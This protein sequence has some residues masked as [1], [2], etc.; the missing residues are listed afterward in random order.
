MSAP[1]VRLSP[2]DTIVCYDQKVMINLT[3]D[4]NQIKNTSWNIP[5]Q[6]IGA[7]LTPNK[8]TKILVTIIDTNNCVTTATGIVKVK[9]CNT[10]ENC[11]AI[12]AAFTPNNDGK[13]D[14][15]MPIVNRCR[16]ESLSFKIYNRYGKLVFETQKTRRR[17]GWFL[18]GGRPARGTY[19]YMCDYISSSVRPQK[20]GTIILIR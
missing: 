4:M 12:P 20:K 3:G 15:V 17:V 9:D 10:P 11:I 1:S 6:G 13:N 16:I 14:K 2:A 5:A 8:E 19:I 18:Q 7:M